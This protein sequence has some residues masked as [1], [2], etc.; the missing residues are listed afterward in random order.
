MHSLLAFVN[1]YRQFVLGFGRATWILIQFL[2][3]AVFDWKSDCPNA[4]DQLR[5]CLLRE[6]ILKHHNPSRPSRIGTDFSGYAVGAVLYQGQPDGWLSVDYL[7]K[8]KISAEQLCRLLIFLLW[9][10]GGSKGTTSF[11]NKNCL[12]WFMVWRSG[13]T[14]CLEWKQLAK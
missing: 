5:D 11:K 10:S 4:S 13:G 9:R 6:P 7:S 8:T 1:F 14:T 12:L 2:T 3:D